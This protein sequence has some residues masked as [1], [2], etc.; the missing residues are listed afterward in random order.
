MF[1]FEIQYLKK[2]LKLGYT[3]ISND[4]KVTMVAKS[5]SW[6]RTG[7]G[8]ALDIP[9][10]LLAP[11][12]SFNGDNYVYIQGLLGSIYSFKYHWSEFEKECIKRIQMAGYKWFIKTN[13]N[14]WASENDPELYN[15]D[16]V[17]YD[18]P[19]EIPNDILELDNPIS[20]CIRIEDLVKE[21]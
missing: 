18:C 11:K 9:R 14:W 19:V 10:T 7:D 20:E 17:F 15:A 4:G 5:E 13:G 2:L 1:E 8:D 3:C 12:E 6:Y 16:F 21:F